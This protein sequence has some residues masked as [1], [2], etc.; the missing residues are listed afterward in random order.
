MRRRGPKDTHLLKNISRGFDDGLKSR[1]PEKF[2]PLPAELR[3]QHL[4]FI[5]WLDSQG[6]PAEVDGRGAAHDLMEDVRVYVGTEDE[7]GGGVDVVEGCWVVDYG[8]VEVGKQ[9][10]VEGVEAGILGQRRGRLAVSRREEVD[11]GFEGGELVHGG[12]V[13]VALG[14]ASE[15]ETDALGG[16]SILFEYSGNE[17]ILQLLI[18]FGI[19]PGSFALAVTA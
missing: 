7:G 15:T 11:D 19:F 3:H 6:V 17:D 4:H 18:S 12:V 13:R 1:Q 5:A 16:A 14:W 10:P 8:D 2:P 9:F